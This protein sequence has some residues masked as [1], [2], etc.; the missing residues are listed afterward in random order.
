VGKLNSV[1][2]VPLIDL[3]GSNSLAISG[4][5][6]TVE[7]NGGVPNKPGLF[8]HSDN[9]SAANPFYGGTLCLAPPII[10]GAPIAFDTF[11]YTSQAVPFT[12]FDVGT[13]RW[14]QVWYRDVL[15][16]DGIPVGLSGAIQVKYCP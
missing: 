3:V 12:A 8:L 11:G 13:Y 1:G 7:C 16:P 4:G 14:F 2:S 5:N 6:M 10:R 15:S 9:G